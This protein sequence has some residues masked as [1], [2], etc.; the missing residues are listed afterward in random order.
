MFTNVLAFSNADTSRRG[1]SLHRKWPPAARDRSL[2]ATQLSVYC[3]LFDRWHACVCACA[4]ED[5]MP[6]RGWNERSNIT[7]CWA[8]ASTQETFGRL[9]KHNV[10]KECAIDTHQLS[11]IY[12]RDPRHQSLTK[13]SRS[14]PINPLHRVNNNFNFILKFQ[15][16]SISST[17]HQSTI[18]FDLIQAASQMSVTKFEASACHCFKWPLRI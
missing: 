13:L 11:T 3:L 15:I 8:A 7:R 18:R 17:H 6:S 1:W 4:V 16:K 12:S 10:S 5:E 9:R 14:T 2:C